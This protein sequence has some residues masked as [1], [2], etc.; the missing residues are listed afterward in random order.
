MF[1]G[2]FIVW[3][4]SG[5]PERAEKKNLTPIINGPSGVGGQINPPSVSPN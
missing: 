5:G 1:L 2:L 4:L 3:V